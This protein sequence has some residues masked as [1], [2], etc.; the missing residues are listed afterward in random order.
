MT[1]TYRA[2]ITDR[3]DKLKVQ[4]TETKRPANHKITVQ[5]AEGMLNDDRESDWYWESV[6]NKET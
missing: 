6:Y 5:D 2:P 1:N 4:R 3:S